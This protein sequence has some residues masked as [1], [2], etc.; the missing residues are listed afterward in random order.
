[1]TGALLHYRPRRWQWALRA[2]RPHPAPNHR[3]VGALPKEARL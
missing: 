2:S 1:V 3:R